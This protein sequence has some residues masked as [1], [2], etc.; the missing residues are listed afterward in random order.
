MV[1]HSVSLLAL[2]IFPTLLGITGMLYL[3]GVA[4]LGAAMLALSATAAAE[5]SAPRARRVF[6][7]SLLYQPLL[8]AL[9]LLDT[10]RA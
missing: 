1:Y 10:V 4:V 2:S 8:M 3:A 7:F 6:L 5:M 9:L